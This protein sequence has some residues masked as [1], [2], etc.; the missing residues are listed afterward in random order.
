MYSSPR[1]GQI[2]LTGDKDEAQTYDI[3]CLC[4]QILP[5]LKQSFQEL[6][7]IQISEN[8]K[9]QIYMIKIKLSTWKPFSLLFDLVLNQVSSC[10]TY[11]DI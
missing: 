4:S 6:R 8:S 1:F 5:C 10:P 11:Y 9:I 2:T 7:D 3:T